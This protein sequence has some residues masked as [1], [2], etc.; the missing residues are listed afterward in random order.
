MKLRRRLLAMAVAIGV[1]AG[2]LTVATPAQA[3]TLYDHCELYSACLYYRIDYKGAVTASPDFVYDYFDPYWVTF[4]GPN[5][6]NNRGSTDGRGRAVGNATGSYFNAEDVQWLIIYEHR[7]VVGGNWG[8]A[9]Y[10]APGTGSGPYDFTTRNNN[11]CQYW[12][13]P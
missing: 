1:A 9:D 11:R 3:V 6:W 10:F 5:D 13:V 12:W 4:L 2:G 7:C 8:R